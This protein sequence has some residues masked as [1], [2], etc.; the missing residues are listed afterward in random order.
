MR[1]NVSINRILTALT[2]LMAYA[3]IAS[4]PALAAPPPA[5]P[6]APPSGTALE[7]TL[8]EPMDGQAYQ[9][10][11]KVYEN[12]VE[13][14]PRTF[15]DDEVG[16]DFVVV[17]AAVPGDVSGLTIV[18][19]GDTPGSGVRVSWDSAIISNP[20]IYAMT[21][22]GTGL[23]Q[24]T[25]DED[26]WTK[27]FDAGAL[28][29]NNF[30]GGSLT[31]NAFEKSITHD[32]QV[33]SNAN[34]IYYKAVA[35]GVDPVADPVAFENAPAVGRVNVR[36]Q[37]EYNAICYP[38]RAMD[39][40]IAYIIGN[41]L[42]EGDQVHY[43]DYDKQS[44][45]ILTKT[46]SWPDHTFDSVEGVYVYMVASGGAR[47]EYLALVGNVG[48]FISG[49]GKDLG[50]EYN[51]VGYPYPKYGLA[52][53]IGLSPREGDQIHQWNWD[54]QG[55]TLTTFVNNAWKD[56]NITAFRLSEGKFY[57]IPVTND[58]LRWELTY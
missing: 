51:L 1:R 48:G 38:F 2:A 52:N 34:E 6:P 41:Q 44:Y 56:E 22:D 33:G 10:Q 49:F 13:I 5:P 15:Y 24:K 55:F 25:Y 23:Y 27:I 31:Y 21:R 46:E 17:P 7:F 39:Y 32:N 28:A 8:D 35:N 3:V 37:S 57:Y 30:N 40:G 47:D 50:R 14:F 20:A 18:R 53:N 58:P 9:L 45:E 12:G 42:A 11:F 29:V 4:G 43:W 26:V 16:I 54:G 36:V 19:E